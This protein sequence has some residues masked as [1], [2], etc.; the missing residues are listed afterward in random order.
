MHGPALGGFVSIFADTYTRAVARQ[1]VYA[2]DERGT[3][4]PLAN[5]HV[6]D[7]YMHM[8]L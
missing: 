3:K 8:V 4:T 2:T 6:R 5:V 1:Y 7:V